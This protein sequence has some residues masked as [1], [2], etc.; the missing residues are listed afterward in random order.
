MAIYGVSPNS[1]PAVIERPTRRHS[2]PEQ[3]AHKAGRDNDLPEEANDS[4]EHGGPSLARNYLTDWW[5]LIL[6]GIAIALLI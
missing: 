1:K 4:R 5:P 3:S 6:A 2:A